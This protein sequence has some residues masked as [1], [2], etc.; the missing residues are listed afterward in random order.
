MAI[1]DYSIEEL[2][3]ELERKKK[4]IKKKPKPK[5]NVDWSELK[6]FVV[7]G[8]THLADHGYQPKDFEHYIYE[9]ALESIYG[10]KIWDW[11]NEVIL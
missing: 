3:A 5:S 2:E 4:T 6:E 11:I 9:Q 7:A 1:K 8:I 10:E